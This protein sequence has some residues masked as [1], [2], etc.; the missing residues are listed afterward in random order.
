MGGLRRGGGEPRP[1]GRG[2][3]R[4]WMVSGRASREVVIRPGVGWALGGRLLALPEAA[5]TRL[6][7]RELIGRAGQWCSGGAGGGH[8][9]LLF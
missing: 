4:R 3:V 2:W 8:G 5:A 1:H 7:S 6:V 9:L